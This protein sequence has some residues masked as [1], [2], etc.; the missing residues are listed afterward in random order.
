MKV[1]LGYLV[2]GIMAL[3]GGASLFLWS[4][5]PT[6]IALE[7]RVPGLDGKNLANVAGSDLGPIGG[8]PKLITGTGKPAD[9]PG[10]WPCFRG[11]GHD[12]V[13]SDQVPLMQR[14]PPGGP[15]A[16]W[17]VAL[18]EG[19]AGPV[20][21]DGRVYIL[22][23]E[24]E[25]SADA[26]RCLS[27]ADGQEIWRYTYPVVVKR[28]HGMSR[29]VPAVAEG[30]VVA[31]G[32]KCHVT[33]VDAVKGDRYWTIDLVR[34]HGTIVPQWY[35]G[36]CPLIDGDKVI[37]A[38]GGKDALLMAVDLKTGKPA[39]KTPNPHGWQMTHSSVM[40]MKV[41]DR[42]TYVYCAS[43]GVVGVDAQTGK[44]LWE[45]ADWK[46]SMA[47][48]P[49]PVCLA[50]GRVFLCGGYGAG[51]MML[52]VNDDEG[53]WTVSSLFRLK[54]KQFSS[55]QHTPILYHDH[56]YGVREDD[57]E[58]VCL[59]LDG[60]VVWHSGS[61]HRFGGGRGPYLL[62]DGRLFVLDEEGELVIAEASPDGY[63]E[64]SRAK[65]LKGKD[66]WAPMALA[67]GRLLVRDTGLMVCLDVKQ[68]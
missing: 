35:A 55:T 6:N 10:S 51:A 24:H 65:V 39:W 33:C 67:A 16:L 1:F 50:D 48:V 66:A 49:A 54:P 36:Q 63:K 20:I 31:L 5:P 37:L 28:D 59:D 14:F 41:K 46:I 57:Q 19:Y 2:P 45:T 29:T 8:S 42:M 43:G 30:R 17:S 68:P 40:P 21:H 7:K 52:Q 4:H 22:D 56:L 34:E 12:N 47:T 15:K 62:A 9:L 53:G 18:G 13:A 23:Y 61:Q 27:L 64:L 32:P 60:K 11:A 26:L 25:A 58:L 38:P 44:Q 3:A